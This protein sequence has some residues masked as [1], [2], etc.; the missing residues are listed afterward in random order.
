M[1]AAPRGSQTDRGVASFDRVPVDPCRDFASRYL[2]ARRGDPASLSWLLERYADDVR[3]FVRRRYRGREL[4]R[5]VDAEDLA[6]ASF[7]TFVERLPSYPERLDEDQVR[8]RLLK[9]VAWSIGNALRRPRRELREASAELIE[10]AS[11]QAS[12][13]VVTQA[14]QVRRLLEIVDKMRAPYATVVRLRLRGLDT[15]QIAAELGLR[16]EAVKKRLARAQ[17]ELRDR[18]KDRATRP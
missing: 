14:D 9:L 3:L 7:A 18:L 11:P 2:A 17:G 13:G 10:P 6:Q 16:R 4:R 12:T 5:R 8:R 1:D 15:D